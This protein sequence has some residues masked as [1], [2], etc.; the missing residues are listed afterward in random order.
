MKQRFPG[1]DECMRLMRRH[2]RK[3]REDGFHALL[4]H[5]HEHVDELIPAFQSETEHGLRCWLLELLG[6]ARSVKA[7]ALLVEQLHGD[8]ESLRCWAARGL[9]LLATKEARRALWEASIH[10]E[11]GTR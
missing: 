1:F 6:E 8:D 4:P 11:R 5:A 2:N 7:F 3:L 10:E 9:Q